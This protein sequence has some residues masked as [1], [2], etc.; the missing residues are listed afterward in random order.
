MDL[1]VFM[2]SYAAVLSMMLSLGTSVAPF[3]FLKLANLIPWA[4]AMA[5]SLENILILAMLLRYPDLTT[6]LA[7]YAAA[8]SRLKWQLLF[9]AASAVGGVGLY[10]LGVA[11][12]RMSQGK[13]PQ[14]RLEAEARRPQ[15]QRTSKKQR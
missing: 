15:Q 11:A 6:A 13:R 3:E 4:A 1:A 10:C 5:D 8:A 14:D 9:V 12:K 2:W 7:P